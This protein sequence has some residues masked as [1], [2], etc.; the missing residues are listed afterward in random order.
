MLG[1]NVILGM[2]WLSSYHAVIHC[3]RRRVTVCTS[4]GDCFYFLGNR[5][6]SV[7]SPTYD[8]SGRGELS[9]LF[10]ALLGSESDEVRVELPRV[11][12]EYPDVFPE[13]NTPKLIKLT[14]FS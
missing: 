13:C 3:Y 5:A 12:C 8:L 6:D 11:V 9:C 2:D 10:A 14:H 7:L 1:F 4:N